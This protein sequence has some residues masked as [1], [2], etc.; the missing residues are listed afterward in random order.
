MN[1][2]AKA[3][4]RTWI[5]PP[6]LAE[7]LGIDVGKVLTWIRNG[8]LQAVNVAESLGGRPRWRISA[9]AVDAFLRRRHS[10]TPDKPSPRRRRPGTYINRHY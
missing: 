9:E 7:L 2:D 3:K 5:N 8:E 6:K 10:P 4:C 1:E